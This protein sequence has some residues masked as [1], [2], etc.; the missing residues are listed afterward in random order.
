MLTV[1]HNTSAVISI[2]SVAKH[3]GV[4]IIGIQ[5][6]VQLNMANNNLVIYASGHDCSS[7][8]ACVNLVEIENNNKW[9]RYY[10]DGVEKQFAPQG[11]GDL[12]WYEPSGIPFLIKRGQFAVFYQNGGA[13]ITLQPMPER[14]RSNIRP[15]IKNKTSLNPFICFTCMNCSCPSI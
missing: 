1:K 7:D 3:D 14:H 9:E 15:S 10:Y 4:T 6:E 13:K 2:T 5:N 8:P 11:G 12:P